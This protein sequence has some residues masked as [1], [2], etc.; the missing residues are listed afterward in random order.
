M[1]GS[2]TFPGAQIAADAQACAA[3]LQA[4]AEAVRTACAD[5]SDAIRLLAALAVFS[6]PPVLATDAIGQAMQTAQ[7]ATAAA[8]RRAALTSLARAAAEYQPVSYQDAIAVRTTAC[9]LL[10]AEATLAADAGDS[11]TYHAL[12]ALRSA[13]FADL[14]ARGASLAKVRLVRT[15]ASLPAAV[16]AQRL[17]QDPTRSDQLVDWANPWHPLFMP[18]SFR[19]LAS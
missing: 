4:V 7:T 9:T 16:L 14:T 1:S 6:P 3:G 17:Y 13:V 15:R 19:A 12:W 10:D 2:T 18:T 8:C 11:D 5:P